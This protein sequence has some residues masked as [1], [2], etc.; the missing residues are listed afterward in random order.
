MNKLEKEILQFIN[1]LYPLNFIN[2]TPITN[3]MYKCLTEQGT[4]FIRITNYKTYEE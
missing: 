1:K 2:I 3:E 4:Y